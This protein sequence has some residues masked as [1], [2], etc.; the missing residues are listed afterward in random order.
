MCT[1]IASNENKGRIIVR[2]I[3]YIAKMLMFESMHDVYFGNQISAR[4]AQNIGQ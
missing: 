3:H 4:N 2:K 1:N